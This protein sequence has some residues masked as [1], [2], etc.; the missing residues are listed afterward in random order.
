MPTDAA[1]DAL[2]RYFRGVINTPRKKDETPENYEKSR[3]WA[4]GHLVELG[5][6]VEDY[7]PEDVRDLE[8]LLYRMQGQ[9]PE[10]TAA[11]LIE[12]GWRKK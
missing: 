9:S 1:R 8:N 5:A 7:F 3:H 6:T 4:L 2:L 10:K 12:K 11:Y